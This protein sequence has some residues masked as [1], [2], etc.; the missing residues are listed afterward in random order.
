M[1]VQFKDFKILL[2]QQNGRKLTCSCFIYFYRWMEFSPIKRRRNAFHF[3]RRLEI[4][5]HYW[6]WIL[7]VWPH[8]KK[9]HTFDLFVLKKVVSM[10]NMEW[11]NCQETTTLCFYMYTQLCANVWVWNS[12]HGTLIRSKVNGELSS[13]VF[14]SVFFFFRFG[15][16]FFCIRMCYTPI[17]W[18]KMWNRQKTHVKLTLEWMSNREIE[19]L[20]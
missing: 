16:S 11:V 3:F 14:L 4:Q 15:S 17:H 10:L 13:Y 8:N 2:K 1:L 7:F 18:Q 9:D 5:S 20:R 19:Q 12:T 6:Y